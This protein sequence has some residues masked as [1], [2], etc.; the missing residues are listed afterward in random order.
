MKYSPILGSWRF[1]G[2]PYQGTHARSG[3]W[4]TQNAVDMMAPAGTKVIAP[5]NI[6][7]TNVKWSTS[8]RPGVYGWQVH[9][10][11]KTGGHFFTHMDTITPQIKP[12]AN[13]KAGQKIGALG[14]GPGIPSHLHYAHSWK[15]PTEIAYW[16]KRPPAPIWKL[17]QK[18]GYRP[19][20]NWK[21]GKGAYARFGKANKLVRPN[22]PK[23]IRKH[24]PRWFPKLKRQLRNA[25]IRKRVGP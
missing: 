18:R 12:G 11:G 8:G 21:L 14:P 10:V 20:K 9:G 5:E 17:K 16:P 3:G 25:A 2:G 7:I 24:R 13:L 19:W 4:A 22:V 1:G 6:K 23:N 15:N